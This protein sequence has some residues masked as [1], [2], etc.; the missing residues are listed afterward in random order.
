M[1]KWI[2]I[3]IGLFFF[4]E[5]A[6]A[7]AVSTA[8]STVEA[9]HQKSQVCAT[10]HNQDGNST[11]PAWPKIAGQSEKYLIEQLKEYRKGDKGNRFNPVMYNL[12][13]NLSD[14]DIE[15]LATFFASQKVA[16]G[17]AKPESVALG[18]KIYRGGNPATGVPACAACHDPHGQGNELAGFPLL[19][20]QQPQYMIDQLKAFRAGTRAN[21][22][23]GIMREISKRM[24]DAEIEAVGNYVS[25]LH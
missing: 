22:P 4:L 21:D 14:Q 24:T 17:A 6:M 11:V 25:G 7:E 8:V 3:G 16:L 10:C 20:G 1:G 15:D 2:G 23:M 5:V 9:G 18:E 12:V 13:T 19:S